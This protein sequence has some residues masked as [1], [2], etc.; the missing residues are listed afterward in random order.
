MPL[1]EGKVAPNGIP[2]LPHLPKLSKARSLSQRKAT[3]SDS[4]KADSLLLG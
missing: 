3:L 4:C 1:I 2:I